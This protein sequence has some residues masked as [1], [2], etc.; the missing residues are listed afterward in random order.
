MG[1]KVKFDLNLAGLNEVMKRP[2]LQSI[3]QAKGDEI[4][5]RATSSAVDPEAEYHAET[6]T[7]NWIAVTNIKCSN[8]AAIHE[9][10]EHNTLL[11]S[12]Y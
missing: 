4:A 5:A 2:A 10:Y 9:N 6:K 8:G 3:M 7:I 12:L 11:K 1:K